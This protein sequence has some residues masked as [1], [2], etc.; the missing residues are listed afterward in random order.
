MKFVGMGV[1]M[2]VEWQLSFSFY[3]DGQPWHHGQ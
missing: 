2:R 3:L 1:Y